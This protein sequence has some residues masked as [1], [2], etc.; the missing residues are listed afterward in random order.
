MLAGGKMTR[1]T[2]VVRAIAVLKLTDYELQKLDAIANGE[3]L[4]LLSLLNDY[5]L[6]LFAFDANKEQELVEKLSGSKLS[7]LEYFVLDRYWRIKS[8][9]SLKVLSRLLAGLCIGEFTE[10][11]I[12]EMEQIFNGYP[13][14]Y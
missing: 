3:D 9:H 2:R 7:D 5:R 4:K 14:E 13:T 6:M 10:E 12:I 1:H 8:H 11:Q